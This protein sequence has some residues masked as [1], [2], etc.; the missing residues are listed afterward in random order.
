MKRPQVGTM[1]VGVWLSM[2]LM[3][4]AQTDTARVVGTVS[5]TSGAIIP[6]VTVT[7]TSEKTGAQRSAVSDEKGY[8]V[9]TP[10]LPS[11]YKVKA[12]Q[13]GFAGGEYSGVVLQIG[14]EKTLN[15]VLKPAGV[16]AEVTVSGGDLAAIDT[17]SARVG[18]NV[19]EREV[20]SLPLNGR[21]VSQ[22]YLMTPGATNYGAGT[23]DD[24]RFSGRSVEQN[25]VR[26]DGIEGTSIVDTSPGN[27]NGQT[28]SPFRLQTSMENVQEFRVESSNYPA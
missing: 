19:S 9:V 21:Q 5:D 1:V 2:S 22:L 7:V 20:N 6:G 23:F 18:V 10:L 14:Q 12:E 28:A 13:P 8:F 3:A 4:W 24:V 26:F 27:L 16:T 15:L 25:E 17:S 11:T